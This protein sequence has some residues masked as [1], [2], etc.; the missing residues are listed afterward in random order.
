MTVGS[1]FSGIGGIDKGETMGKTEMIH[2]LDLFSYQ[3]PPHFDGAVYDKEKDLVRL[4]GQILRVWDIIKDGQWRTVDE[5]HSSIIVEH[6]END[7]ECSISAQ[8][9][10][11]RKARFGGHLIDKQRR[12]GDLSALWE[13]RLDTDLKD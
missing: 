12:G 7:P 4:T 11:L 6:N 8:L 2:I 1:L 9:R 3:Q 10:N 5:I 13:Y